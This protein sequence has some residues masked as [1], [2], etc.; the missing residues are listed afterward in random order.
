MQ[1]SSV[2]RKL[3]MVSKK[4][5]LK[6]NK[7]LSLFK[8]NNSNNRLTSLSWR[9][10]LFLLTLLIKFHIFV[11]ESRLL[12]LDIFYCLLWVI[13]K[14]VQ[15]SCLESLVNSPKF[16]GLFCGTCSFNGKLDNHR[17]FSGIIGKIRPAMY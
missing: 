11:F 9:W 17:C 7:M 8:N 3:M 16:V 13:W 6:T 1:N 5:H 10:C 14:Y 2:G 15:Y 4:K 12:I